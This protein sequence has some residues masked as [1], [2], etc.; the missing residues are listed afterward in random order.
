MSSYLYQSKQKIMVKYGKCKQLQSKP[1]FYNWLKLEYNDS[2]RE[3]YHYLTHVL[4]Q[5]QSGY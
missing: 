1:K 3:E 4:H 5:K 2:H